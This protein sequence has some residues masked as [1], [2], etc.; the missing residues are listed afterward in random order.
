MAALHRFRV[1]RARLCRQNPGQGAGKL[2]A[3]QAEYRSP[4]TQRKYK[5]AWVGGCV[6]YDTAKLREFAD[7]TV[8]R[9]IKTLSN[10]YSVV[11]FGGYRRQLQV[12]VDR[13][14]LTAYG[15]SILESMTGQTEQCLEHLS[16]AIG[17]NPQ[18]RIHA[19]VDSD[20][21]DMADDPRFTELLYP[22][23]Q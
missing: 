12:I 22:E 7:N 1:L 16:Q 19:R 14:K 5:I 23:V 6:L 2:R 20:F 8:I 21:Q 18:N 10:V 17:I 9:R 11:T 4:G 3:S 13:N 15:L